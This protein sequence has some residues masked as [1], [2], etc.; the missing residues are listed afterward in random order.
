[1]SNRSLKT[2]TLG[3]VA[4]VAM[5]CATTAPEPDPPTPTPLPTRVERPT[6]LPPVSVNADCIGCDVAIPRGV[7]TPSLAMRDYNAPDK[8]LLVACTRGYSVEGVAV[9]GPRGRTNSS[10]IAVQGF[11]PK[12]AIGIDCFAITA[13]Y[14]GTETYCRNRSSSDECRSGFGADESILTFRVEGAVTKL[15][16]GQYGLMERYAALGK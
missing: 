6:P 5:A 11:P 2:L 15:D 10:E 16:G 9:M 14:V 1:M 8:V 13:I 7:A 12:Q 3:I 4:V